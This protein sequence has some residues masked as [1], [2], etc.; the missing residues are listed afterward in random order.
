MFEYW[1]FNEDVS[2]ILLSVRD[3]D[4]KKHEGF[5]E[6]CGDNLWFFQ[7]KNICVIQS[8]HPFGDGNLLLD[9]ILLKLAKDFQVHDM[10]FKKIVISNGRRS[11]SSE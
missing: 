9:D 8:L 11:K 10:G 3:E 1:I 7:A 2:S 5:F 6:Y 4:I